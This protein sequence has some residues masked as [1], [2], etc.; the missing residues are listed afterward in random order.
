[1][2]ERWIRI[3]D[4]I[5]EF[6]LYG[7]IFFIPISKAAIEIFFAFAFTAFILKKILKPN[8]ESLRSPVYLLLFCFIM[9]N[10]ISLINSGQYFIKSIISLFFK[11]MEYILIFIMI[12]DTF[13]SHKRIR[14]TLFIILSISL[15][16]GID[17]LLQYFSASDFLR[18]RS[19]GVVNSVYAITASFNHYNDFGAYLVV[20]LSLVFALFIST[21]EKL[22]KSALFLL[23]V[24]LEVCLLL[25][26]SR[27]AWLGF[28]CVF[29]LMLFI[30]RKF[31]E[32]ISIMLAFI[33]LI[34]SLPITRERW[35]FIFS[36]GGD[37]SRFDLWKLTFSMIK[38]NPFL[39]KGIGTFMDHFSQRAPNL[40]TQYAHNCFLQIWAETG[41]FSL[42]SFLT[43]ITLLLFRGIAVFKKNNNYILLG[44]SCGIFGFL[45]HSFF[46]T[47]LYSLQLSVLFWSMAGILVAATK[48]KTEVSR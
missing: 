26:F 1:M 5:C 31:T 40:Y 12:G 22:Y 14:N 18:H 41:I 29:F 44:I 34:I 20:I 33:I 2:K 10:A 15:L 24:L 23:A 45:V 11:W 8:F 39:G 4:F 27:G 17:G 48:L 42:S 43:F 7:L 6:S 19:V 37:A 32:V 13:N 9:F 35:A 28:I 38:E 21:Q 25:T 30:S 3:L 36:I 46:D 47:H 16:I